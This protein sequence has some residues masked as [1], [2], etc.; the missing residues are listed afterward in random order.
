MPDAA[1]FPEAGLLVFAVRADEGG[2]ELVVDEALEVGA[3]E[4]FVC[5]DG[6][7]WADE[8]SVVVKERLCDFA[9]PDFGVRE[10]PNDGHSVGCAEE[11]EAEAPEVSGV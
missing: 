1:E 5:H 9:F 8:V 6:L 2:S 3:G 4:A 7:S 10:A 11:V